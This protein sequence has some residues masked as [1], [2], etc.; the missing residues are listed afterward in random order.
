MEAAWTDT[1]DRDRRAAV[2][3]TT[4]IATRVSEGGGRSRYTK[5]FDVDPLPGLRA[6]KTVDDL[7]LSLDRLGVPGPLTLSNP[8][9]DDTKLGEGGQFEVYSGGLLDSSNCEVETELE[10]VA[11]KRP[12]FEVRNDRRLDL[13]SK[14]S[15]Q[16]IHNM[17]LEVLALR[18]QSLR[19]HRNIVRLFGWG[20]E[21]VWQD[22]PSLVVELATGDLRSFFT[23]RWQDLGQDS[24]HQLVIDIGH[25]LDAVH[26]ERLVHGDLKPENVLV[27]DGYSAEVR[28]IAKLADFGLAS[29]EFEGVSDGRIT[30]LGLSSEWC[31]P[32]ITIDITLHFS[33][34]VKADVLSFGMLLWS[35][36]C[37]KCQPPPSKRWSLASSDTQPYLDASPAL[38]N[39]LQ[40][41]LPQLLHQDPTH[42]PAEVGDALK[43]DSPAYS[44]WL[45]DENE[46]IQALKASVD[47]SVYAWQLPSLA[48]FF[49]QGLDKSYVRHKSWM[50]GE[51]L[52]AMFLALTYADVGKV[53]RSI[54]LGAL[55][56][57][58]EKR[59]PP[60]EAVAARVYRSYQRAHI[61]LDEVEYARGNSRLHI[62]AARGRHDEI[63]DILS[64]DRTC[65]GVNERNTRGE[66]ALYKAC[67][68]GDWKTVKLL[69]LQGPDASLS[70]DTYGLTCLHW[71]FNVDMEHAG[72]VA[73]VLVQ[74]GGADVNA[75]MRSSLAMANYHFPFRWPSGTPLHWAIFASSRSAITALLSLG[76]GSDLRDGRDPYLSDEN[77]RQLHRHGTAEQGEFS[78]PDQPPQGFSSVDLA[79]AMHDAE[80]LSCIR[81]HGSEPAHF[82][83]DEEGYTPLHRLSYFRLARTHSGLRFWYP[84]FTGAPDEVLN[85]M[86]RAVKELLLMGGDINQLTHRPIRPARKGVSGL[87]PLMIAVTKADNL[88]VDALLNCGADPNVTNLDGHTALSLLPDGFCDGSSLLAIVKMLLARGANVNHRSSDHITPLG[89]AA[90]SGHISVMRELVH[91]GADLN[92]PSTGISP[93]AYTILYSAYSERLQSPWPGMSRAD[94]E[95][96][97]A[98]IVEMLKELADRD[99]AWTKDVDRDHRTLLHHAAAAGLTK[100]VKLLLAE[101]GA[102]PD[103]YCEHNRDASS[104]TYESW[105]RA[106]G[107]GTP[108]DLVVRNKQEFREH[109]RGR[110]STQGELPL[111]RIIL[112]AS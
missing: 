53:D 66:T 77:V 104:R 9:K 18:R 106:M 74:K 22:V 49:F 110:M 17:Y 20:L 93:I 81:L 54:Q 19:D 51:Q 21:Q 63:R 3:E 44:S 56:L 16:Q 87:T 42:R 64:E 62:L 32:E 101:F 50:T 36:S 26:R 38:R 41:L 105:G 10:P 25:G 33:Q 95:A 85:R 102:D 45:E 47:L 7:I 79:A 6:L 100:C 111:A 103:S 13:T 14:A 75:L 109:G 89:A 31:A 43:V 59:Y 34:M 71:L 1:P 91:A 4:S 82:E 24:V 37:F 97:E 8:Y 61:A 90:K 12:R 68:T 67:L 58:K 99:N 94:A 48:A 84:S 70:E 23:Q 73:T 112:A 88:V 11:V 86:I 80:T 5:D 83:G 60:A 15:R 69:C 107:S 65:V 40:S 92:C 76:A 2:T 78:E 27:F 55:M 30:V 96:R 72:N 29:D 52:F 39:V 57:A 35:M 46:R 108:L 98:E 28:F